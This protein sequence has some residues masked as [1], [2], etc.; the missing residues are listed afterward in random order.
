MSFGAV[1]LAFHPRSKLPGI[2]AKANK[3][4]SHKN[5]KLQR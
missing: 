5:A 1:R 2:K 3:L 4:A